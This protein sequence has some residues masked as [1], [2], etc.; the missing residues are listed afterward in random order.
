M[1][2]SELESD[3]IFSV[4]TA[5]IFLQFA[6]LLFWQFALSEDQGTTHKCHADIDTDQ[7]AAYLVECLPDSSKLIFLEF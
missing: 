5:Y 3:A 2:R 1:L 7:T 4:A 6:A